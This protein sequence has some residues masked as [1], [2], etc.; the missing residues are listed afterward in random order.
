MCTTGQIRT[1]LWIEWEFHL[2]VSTLSA[3][4]LYVQANKLADI[5]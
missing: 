1:A 4:L 2:N 3:C 5:L